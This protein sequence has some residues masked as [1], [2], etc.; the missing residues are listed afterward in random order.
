[1]Q[2][3]ISEEFSLNSS[4]SFSNFNSPKAKLDNHKTNSHKNDNTISESSDSG[5]TLD[6]KETDLKQAKN[7][8]VTFPDDFEQLSLDDESDGDQSIVSIR[9]TS[10]IVD[11]KVFKRKIIR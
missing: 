3:L 1:M 8:R 10:S 4:N 11:N 2:K 5:K 7:K 6:S 9:T